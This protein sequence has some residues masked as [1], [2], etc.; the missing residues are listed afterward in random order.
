[1]VMEPATGQNI[2]ANGGM[3]AVHWAVGTTPPPVPLAGFKVCQVLGDSD[4]FEN[5][6]SL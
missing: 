6:I 3:H 4:A 1:M 2:Q 5:I